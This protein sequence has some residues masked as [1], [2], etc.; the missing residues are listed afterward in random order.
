MNKAFA[1]DLLKDVLAGRCDGPALFDRE[2]TAT[3]CI[4]AGWLRMDEYNDPIVTDAGR[5][6]I[7]AHATKRRTAS[8]VRY[9]AL[10]GAG[11]R[12]SRDGWE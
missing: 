7:E 5:R 11:M 3:A 4:D 2:R 10:V 1:I 6:E 12:R 8:R 9:N